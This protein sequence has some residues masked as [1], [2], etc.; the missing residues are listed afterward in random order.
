MAE[1]WV[2]EITVW[3]DEPVTFRLDILSS[4]KCRDIVELEIVDTVPDCLEYAGE[5]VLYVGDQAY[6]REPGHISQ[7]DGGLELSWN[8]L[9]IEALA[10][11]ESVAIEYEAIAEG[12]GEN[13]NTVYA[14]AHCGYDYSVVVDDQDSASVWVTMPQAQDVLQIFLEGYSSCYYVDEP[15]KECQYCEVTI[16]FYARDL[17]GGRLPVTNLALNVNGEPRYSLESISQESIE[18]T[19]VMEA[20]CGQDIHVELMATNSLG[21]EAYLSKTGN[22]TEGALK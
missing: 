20:G 15:D 22:T 9:E 8:L 6:D 21:L 18:D 13:E 19:I 1:D 16:H 3:P 2:D 14:S 17:T 5:A 10:P 4:G 7:G 11:G 12:L